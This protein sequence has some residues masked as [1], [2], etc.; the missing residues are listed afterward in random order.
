M[1]E[2]T[3]KPI[4]IVNRLPNRLVKCIALEIPKSGYPMTIE[5]VSS[6]SSCNQMNLPPDPEHD[7]DHLIG[8]GYQHG[9]LQ[10][11]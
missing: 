2:F 1:A 8:S 10:P 7:A 4:P 9:K 11:H 6:S 3:T 5:T